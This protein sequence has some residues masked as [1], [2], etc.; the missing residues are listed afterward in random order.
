[1]ETQARQ[2]SF[3]LPLLVGL[4]AVV[5][6][7][8]GSASMRDWTAATIAQPGL[9]RASN[10]VAANESPR[11]AHAPRAAVEGAQ[12]VALP[13]DGAVRRRVRCGGCGV[14]ESVRRID[15]REFENGTCSV[16]DSDRF[17]MIGNARDGYEHGA[18]ATLA[19]TVEG[20]LTGRSGGAK[21]KVSSSYQIVVRFRDG[22]RRV[23]NES[24]ARTLQSGE[25]IRVIAGADVPAL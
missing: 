3:G 5:A 13:D 6:A 4:V 22:S 25:Q 24:T 23:F 18:S 7:F 8:A 9:P 11:R 16:A 2:S 19:E 21:M 17:P 20:V 1:M 10:A 15:R 14:V 12:R